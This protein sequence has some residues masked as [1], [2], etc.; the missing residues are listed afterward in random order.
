MNVIGVIY[1]KRK[2]EL[3]QEDVTPPP[4]STRALS[5]ELYCPER[6]VSQQ[7]EL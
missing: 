3:S 6:D 2:L 1:I 7:F 5:L 4:P